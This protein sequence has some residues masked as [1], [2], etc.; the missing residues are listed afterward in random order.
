[1][2][3]KVPPIVKAIIGAVFGTALADGELQESERNVLRAIVQEMDLEEGALASSFEPG[4][5]VG[6]ES[7]AEL[8]DVER[9]EVMRY[10]ILAAVADGTIQQTEA[11][12][13]SD[14]AGRLGL[15]EE[16]RARLEEF[17]RELFRA[18]RRG[19]VDR[20]KARSLIER[21]VR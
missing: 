12:F 2:T 14:L 5:H 15:T 3:R 19:T 20:K 11:S 18:T 21:H 6:R 17:T 16:D 8:T 10:A 1:M 4:Q 9:N 13:L 7:A